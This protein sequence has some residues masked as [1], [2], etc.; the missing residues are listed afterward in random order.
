MQK[1]L[2]GVYALRGYCVTASNYLHFIIVSL[3]SIIFT[4]YTLLQL[5]IKG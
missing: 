1:G 5:L 2:R 3:L 4:H